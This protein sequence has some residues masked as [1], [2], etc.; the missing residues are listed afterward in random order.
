MYQATLLFEPYAETL[1]DNLVR[2][3]QA[4]H[5]YQERE[6]WYLLDTLVRYAALFRKGGDTAAGLNFHSVVI[7]RDGGLK[8]IP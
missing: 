4:Q 6:V 2:N 5:R 8:I 7:T 1:F 3:C